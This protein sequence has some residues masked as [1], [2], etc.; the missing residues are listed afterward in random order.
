MDSGEWARVQ[1]ISG[2]EGMITILAPGY[3]NTALRSSTT[4]TI[5]EFERHAMFLLSSLPSPE[6]SVYFSVLSLSLM[7][8]HSLPVEKGI[9]EYSVPQPNLSPYMR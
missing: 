5:V 3:L 8:V 2:P 9:G 7:G 6:G 1:M 4:S